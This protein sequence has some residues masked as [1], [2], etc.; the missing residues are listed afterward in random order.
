M[1]KQWPGILC[2][3]HASYTYKAEN[4]HSQTLVLFLGG[5]ENE[6]LF[7][8]SNITALCGKLNFKVNLQQKLI[9]TMTAHYKPANNPQDSIGCTQ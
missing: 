9:A 5:Q 6:N 8:H 7:Q 1:Q 4:K 2:A 3:F